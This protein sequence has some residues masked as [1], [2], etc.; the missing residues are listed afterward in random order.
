MRRREQGDVGRR[1]RMSNAQPQTNRPLGEHQERA[2]RP[3]LGAHA[4]GT[5]GGDG[6]SAA[7]ELGGG[8]LV[9]AGIGGPPSHSRMATDPRG[10]LGVPPVTWYPIHM[11]AGLLLAERA[12]A[13]PKCRAFG[14][15]SGLPAEESANAV[16]NTEIVND[17]LDGNARTSRGGKGH[18]G[19]EVLS[20]P[21]SLVET[22]QKAP[23]RNNA[24]NN[25]VG[26]HALHQRNPVRT[27]VRRNEWERVTRGM[28]ALQLRGKRRDLRFRA[29]ES[30]SL[31]RL[32][33]NAT[34]EKALFGASSG[35][36]QVRG[37]AEDGGPAAVPGQVPPRRLLSTAEASHGRLRGAQRA[38]VRSAAKGGQGALTA[39]RVACVAEPLSVSAETRVAGRAGGDRSSVYGTRLR[40]EK[41]T[42]PAAAHGSAHGGLAVPEEVKLAL[43]RT[44]TPSREPVPTPSLQRLAKAT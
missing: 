35:L 7:S 44:V 3:L 18:V 34:E 29:G 30:G 39:Q 26:T 10:P 40:G 11:V 41:R 1:D 19:A 28:E 32:E 5:Q 15:A 27:T 31:A 13:V 21:R 42:L 2:V 43:R 33:R 12:G 24:G 8:L 14:V 23:N 38:E 25:A 4:S 16:T 22:W 9:G 37:G 20:G 36:T 17:E 6:Q